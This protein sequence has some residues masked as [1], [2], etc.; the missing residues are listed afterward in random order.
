MRRQ[1]GARDCLG[2][3]GNN[4]PHQEVVGHHRVDR[5]AAERVHRIGGVIDGGS[6]HDAIEKKPDLHHGIVARF[7]RL[8]RRRP[9]PRDGVEAGLR[10]LFVVIGLAEDANAMTP[11]AQP[12]RGRQY[13]I[14]VSRVAPGGEQEIQRHQS[15]LEIAD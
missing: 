8:Q 2:L 12:P 11:V 15:D 13:R 7:R 14:E 10:R 5:L 3:G 4:R 1:Q 9:P 6:E